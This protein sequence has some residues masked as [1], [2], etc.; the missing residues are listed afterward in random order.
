MSIKKYNSKSKKIVKQ[1]YKN[2]KSKKNTKKSRKSKKNRKNNNLK[3]N[4]LKSNNLKNKKIKEM[5]GGFLGCPASDVVPNSSEY[6]IATLKKCLESGSS[7]AN[8]AEYD[9]LFKKLKLT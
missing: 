3:S 9:Y 7:G 1:K 4:N 2:I 8:A 5:L 6:N